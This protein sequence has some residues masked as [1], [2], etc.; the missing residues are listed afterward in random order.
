MIN[1]KY[2]WGSEVANKGHKVRSK[3]VNGLTQDAVSPAGVRY[4]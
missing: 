2:T 1:V 3:A 4:K